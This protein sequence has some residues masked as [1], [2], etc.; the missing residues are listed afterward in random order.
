MIK[1]GLKDDCSLLRRFYEIL[2]EAERKPEYKNKAEHYE[3]M[4]RSPLR[5]VYYLGILKDYRN[6]FL[7]QYNYMKRLEKENEELKRKLKEVTS[8]KIEV[9]KA[10]ERRRRKR[11]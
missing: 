10:D 5:Y 9:K 8:T 2:Y 1:I 11:K 4:E 6:V 7:S 3:K